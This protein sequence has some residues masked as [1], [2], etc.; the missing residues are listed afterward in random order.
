MEKQAD[1]EKEVSEY[2]REKFT[3]MCLQ[4]EDKDQRLRLESGIIATLNSQSDFN[5]S[6]NWLGN[7]NTESQLKD[8]GLWI[9]KGLDAEV[10]TFDEIKWIQNN[11]PQQVI[12]KASEQISS[13]LKT[14]DD[15]R[16]YLLEKLKN[17]K[18]RGLDHLIIKAGDVGKEIGLKNR[19]PMI[20]DAMRSIP[21][22]GN[23]EELY[24]PPKGKGTRLKHKYFL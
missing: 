17:A 23:Y 3:F 13:P 22:F 8:S 1:V 20:C 14:T 5:P 7:Y 19:T 11:K 2:I 15:I 10:L 16:N 21:G 9:I 6:K 24:R 4:V 12:L 18:D